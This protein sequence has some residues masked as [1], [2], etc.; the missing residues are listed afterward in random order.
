MKRRIPLAFLSFAVL[1][2]ISSLPSSAQSIPNSAA[3]KQP[4]PPPCCGYDCA[5]TCSNKP[6]EPTDC[7]TTPYGPARANIVVGSNALASTNMLFCPGGTT[8]KPRPYALCFFSGPLSPTGTKTAAATNKTLSCLPDFNTGIAN[9]QC[10]VYSTTSY[11]VDINSILNMGAFWQTVKAC[12]PDGRGCKNIAGCDDS[13]NPKTSCGGSPCPPCTD[14]VA[15]VCDY[16]A[17]QPFD[18]NAGLYPQ[19]RHASMSR[20]DLVSTFSYA[21]SGPASAT[22][23]AGYG[24]QLGSTACTNNGVYAGC[25]T[26][27]CAYPEGSTKADGSIV[28]CAC[29]MWQG[30]YQ[31]GQAQADLQATMVCPVD[32]GWVW[33]AANAVP[34]PTVK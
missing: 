12:G 23:N 26:A 11:Y 24:Y 29:P 8:D 17:A 13:G 34:A 15:P 2:A 4:C 14:K 31:I 20:V 9:C 16:V 3:L 10:Q 32:A 5:G 18:T 1:V 22:P 28:N 7:A 21:M 30:D 19:S 27:P 25:M 6:F 33:S